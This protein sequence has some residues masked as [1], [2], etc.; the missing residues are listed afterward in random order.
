[1]QKSVIHFVTSNQAFSLVNL[2]DSRYQQ[3]LTEAA[4]RDSAVMRQINFLI[5]FFLPASFVA[6]SLFPTVQ[7]AL[8]LTIHMPIRP[9][10]G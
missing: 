10:L 7:P 8:F 1:M 6:V 9:Y 5:L 2:E 4:V 3:K